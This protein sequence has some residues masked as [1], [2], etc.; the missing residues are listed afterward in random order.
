VELDLSE[1]AVAAIAAAICLTPALL[2]AILFLRR[3]KAYRTKRSIA[4][5]AVESGDEWVL[6]SRAPD[7]TSLLEFRASSIQGIAAQISHVQQ[8]GSAEVFDPRL[9]RWRR[10]LKV[11]EFAAE[12]ANEQER[13]FAAAREAN[14]SAVSLAQQ[15]SREQ[16]GAFK[17]CVATGCGVVISVAITAV[18]LF[19]LIKFI[20]FAWT[21]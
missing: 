15:R 21:F 4:K 20:K 5:K 7:G 1:S 8:S 6:M 14:A 3:E 9:R 11:S 13:R 17:S 2:L 10:A 16:L 19:I 12:W 18:L